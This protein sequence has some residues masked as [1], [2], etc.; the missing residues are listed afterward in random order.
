M[1]T[2]LYGSQISASD[3]LLTYKG[4]KLTKKEKREFVNK[5]FE[6]ILSDIIENDT[7]FNLPTTRGYKASLF[8]DPVEGEDFKQIYKK[9]GFHWI[10]WFLTNFTAYQLKLITEKK[11][12]YKEIRF[13]V[14]GTLL[15]KLIKTI[16]DKSLVK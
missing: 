2:K 9:G 10:D 1:Y 4:Q 8:L 16:Y 5:A 13:R 3:L 7:H 15:D 11:N 14:S 12:S 6:V